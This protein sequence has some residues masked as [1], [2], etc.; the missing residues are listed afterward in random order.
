MSVVDETDYEALNVFPVNVVDVVVT[1][2]DTRLDDAVVVIKRPLRLADPYRAV[3]V[4]P[5]VNDPLQESS[6]IGG[7]EPTLQRYS[8]RIQCLVRHSDEVLGRRLYAIDTKI[9]KAILYRDT[10]LKAQLAALQ[11]ESI[12]SRE[13]FKKF[14]VG[15]QRYLNNDLNGQF[16]YLSVT[17]FHVE[18]EVSPIV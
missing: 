1:A 13:T 11:D 10:N 12:G 6:E 4:F 16:T 7:W 17:E 14:I 3:G 9:I 5:T 8:F 18:T 15:S 2:L